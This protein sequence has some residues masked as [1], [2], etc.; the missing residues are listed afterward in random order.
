MNQLI[1]G[2]IVVG[3]V[4]SLAAA[5]NAFFRGVGDL[6]GGA[7]DSRVRGVSADGRVV[8]GRSISAA[9]PAGEAFRWTIEE[10][11]VALE[12]APGGLRVG[13]AIAASTDGRTIV[14]QIYA[15]DIF[16]AVRWVD[17]EIE[18]LGDLGH[19]SGLGVAQAVSADGTVIVGTSWSPR[20]LEA[21]RWT[22]ATGMV[23][24]G[25]LPGGSFQSDALGVSA[26]GR[27]VVGRS[28][29]ALSPR[30]G[31]QEAMRWEASTGMVPLGDL[32]P[33]DQYFGSSANAISADGLTI[34]GI[35]H[36]FGAY[37]LTR[38][39]ASRGIHLV[40]PSS[41]FYF[42]QKALAVSGDGTV[43]VGEGW[44]ERRDYAAFVWASY[45]ERMREVREV[46]QTNFG[47]DPKGWT[48]TDA[49]G[50]SA[51]GTVIVGN[52]INPEG[53]Q[54]GWV[55][56]LPQPCRADVNRDGRADSADVFAFINAFV[57]RN[58]PDFNGD[59]VVDSGDFFAFLTEFFA[60][61]E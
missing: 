17:G 1:L 47:L 12:P 55:V 5:Q 36:D 32:G 53:Q 43:I 37:F 3:S 49:T 15:T 52:G 10:G 54:E 13:E 22:T 40:W 26:D 14:G 60:G 38:W 20:G 25:D 16:Q 23:G 34:V 41:P 30:P 28:D 31:F 59:R 50:V 7:F 6:P 35:G 21:F 58:A 2:A 42:G 46:M 27:V 56:Y 18:L 4:A 33:E 24:L 44:T 9:A 39:T 29:S 8:V 11:I 51:D 45:A 19:P 61:C 57:N 48:L